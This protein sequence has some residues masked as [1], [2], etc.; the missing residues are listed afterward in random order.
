[1]SYAVTAKYSILTQIFNLLVLPASKTGNT[2]RLMRV[3]KAHQLATSHVTLPLPLSSSLN[4]LLLYYS[5]ITS[6]HNRLS[7]SI[8]SYQLVIIDTEHG[9]HSIQT[10][11]LEHTRRIAVKLVI[12][13][14][15]TCY[16]YRLP[17]HW[18]HSHVSHNLISVITL[19]FDSVSDYSRQGFADLT[20]SISRIGLTVELRFLPHV[21]FG[22][23]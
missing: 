2:N 23:R 9:T 19:L 20:T 4:T 18:T 17:T 5:C 13:Q 11:V 14:A 6:V 8:I 22:G 12:P 10:S 16:P 21:A 15:A 1:M 7:R 3:C